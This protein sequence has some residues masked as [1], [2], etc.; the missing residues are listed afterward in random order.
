VSVGITFEFET[1]R[2][3]AL[4]LPELV[5]PPREAAGAGAGWLFEESAESKMP[6]ECT[7][8]I[9]P[10]IAERCAGEFAL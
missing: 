5:L 6:L 2:A 9:D 1:L 10:R 3:A 7:E 8:L 4:G